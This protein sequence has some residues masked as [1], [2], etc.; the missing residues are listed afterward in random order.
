MVKNSRGELGRGCL[1]GKSNSGLHDD[2]CKRAILREALIE[3]ENGGPSTRFDVEQFLA[4]VD[5]GK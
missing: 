5:D 2:D 3:A 1:P 4:D